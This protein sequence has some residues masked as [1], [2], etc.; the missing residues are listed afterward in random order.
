VYPM[1]AARVR[2]FMRYL[3]SAGRP[4]ERLPVFAFSRDGEP[5]S[6]LINARPSD[7]ILPHQSSIILGAVHPHEPLHSRIVTR[8][9]G[10]QRVHEDLGPVSP[11]ASSG[12]SD[13]HSLLRYAFLL[14]R[15]PPTCWLR[16]RAGRHPAK[17]CAVGCGRCHAAWRSPCPRVTAATGRG[18]CAAALAGTDMPGTLS[19]TGDH[20]LERSSGE[21]PTRWLRDMRR[22]LGG[23]AR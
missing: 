18:M 1:L 5:A 6:P 23:G 17:R 20:W 14:R 10:E 7:D 8:A 2:I 16:P 12:A 22:E 13:F 15:V 3:L 9:P 21:V 4:R 19:D 11:R